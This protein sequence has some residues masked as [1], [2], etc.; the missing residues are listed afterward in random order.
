MRL[1]LLG[2][3][4]SGKGTLAK[5][6]EYEFGYKHFS[7]G[8]LLRENIQNKTKLGLLA[9]PLLD[10][11]QFVPDEI[12]IEVVK[13]KILTQNQGFVLDGFP[14]TLNQAQT[15]SEFT[16]IDKVVY[17]HSD[18]K[19]LSDRL[20]SRRMCS[21]KSCGA[22]YNL[23]HYKNNTCQICGSNL[24]QR[25]D[26]KKEVILKRFKVYQELTQPL[27]EFYKKQGLLVQLESGGTP[28]QTFKEFKEKII[29]GK[30]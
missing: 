1:I 20:S 4:G 5:K 22:I 6:I 12:I 16:N 11:G 28:Q 30:Q 13:D 21:N 9:K 7:T 8:E 3:P 25:D 19:T 2:A 23:N 29:K 27:I 18:N 10:N 15:I 14:R 17:L 24:Y 26:D